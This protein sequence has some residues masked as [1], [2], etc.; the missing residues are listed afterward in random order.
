MFFVP[1]V[2]IVSF[3]NGDVHATYFGLDVTVAGALTCLARRPLSPPPSLERVTVFGREKEFLV[4]AGPASGTRPDYHPRIRVVL[5]LEGGTHLRKAILL[6]TQFAPYL[7]T[8]PQSPRV[9]RK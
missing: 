1:I 6:M 7:R 8:S 9:G 3:F 5:P 2:S 4:D